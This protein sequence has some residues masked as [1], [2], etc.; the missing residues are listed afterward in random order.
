VAQLPDNAEVVVIGGGVMGASVAFHLAEAG[1]DVALVERGQLASGSTS[2]AA[3]G[4][5]MQFSDELNVRMAIRCVEAFERFGE[6][7]GWEIDFK[8]VG[9]LFLLSREEDVAEFERALELQHSLGVPSELLTPAGAK[10]HSP[11]IDTGGVLAATFC[12][13]DG[14]ATPEAVVHGYAAGARRH[15]AHVVTGCE[16]TGI[17]SGAVNTSR[18]TIASDCV[19]CAA[20]AW[21]GQVAALAGVELPVEPLRRQIVFSEPIPGLPKTMPLTIDFATSFYFH[22]EGP[23]VLMGMSDPDETPGFKLE[24]DDAWIPRLL[25]AAGRRAPSLADVGIAGTWAGLYEVT[26]DHNALLGE[27]RAKPFRFVYATGF[28]GHGFQQAPAV[29]EVVR[30]I[31][32]GDDPVVDVS[33]LSADRFRTG[34]TRPEHHVV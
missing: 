34:S 14:H 23:G 17:E 19:V 32:L 28:S 22:R 26:P 27:M 6:R 4:I 29:G 31:V 12:A 30:D 9:Y 8:Q 1:V 5:R 25:D 16:V 20:G 18:G 3:G 10:E 11:L 13:L 33:P 7:P 15:G 24:T 21:S 2:R